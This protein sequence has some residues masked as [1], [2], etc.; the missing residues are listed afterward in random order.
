MP[1]AQNLLLT[2]YYALLGL[3]SIVMFYRAFLIVR[4]YRLPRGDETPQSRFP[5]E[6]VVTV[7]L[8]IFNEKFVV[9]R[10][11]DS[12]CALDWPRDRLEIQLLDDSTDETVEV[13][14]AKVAALRR[15]G[16][17][18]KHLH[19]ED[20]TG[21]KAGALREAMDEARGDFLA[22][23]DADFVPDPDFLRNTVDYFTD[24]KVGFVQTRWE[25][26][27]RGYGMLT[28]GM[29]M[30]MDGHFVRW[31][32]SRARGAAT[33]STS[34][35]QAAY[36]AVSAIDDGQVVG[37][38]TRSARTPTSP[39]APV[40]PATAGSTCARSGAPASFRSRSPR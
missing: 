40:L 38:T 37:K 19:R 26:L 5:E 17:D 4:Y 13:A 8:P 32:R 29:G 14:A 27:N 34:T 1:I 18:V 11:L 22:V 16:F 20:R 31:S 15:E 6:P 35:V 39:T 23:F 33:S 2:I 10:L 3:V 12:V 30:L 7:Q 21:Y 9:E 36:G 25:Y 28:Q 24:T